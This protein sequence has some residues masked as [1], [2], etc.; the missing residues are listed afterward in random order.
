MR[1]EIVFILYTFAYINE[2]MVIDPWR[3]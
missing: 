1:K 2:C 3:V